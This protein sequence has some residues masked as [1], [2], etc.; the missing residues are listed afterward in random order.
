MVE[1]HYWTLQPDDLTLFPELNG[2]TPREIA[3]HQSL[4]TYIHYAGAPPDVNI[5]PGTAFKVNGVTQGGWGDASTRGW[6][7]R[8]LWQ[9]LNGAFGSDQVGMAGHIP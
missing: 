6:F 9:A 7:A 5:S 3:D 2:S 8:A 1:H 4:V